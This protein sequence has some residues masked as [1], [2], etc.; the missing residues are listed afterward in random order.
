MLGKKQYYEKER[1]EKI[2]YETC[3]G[4]HLLF[5]RS[6]NSPGLYVRQ[7]HQPRHVPL[8]PFSY[9]EAKW[10]EMSRVEMGEKNIQSTM[11][12]D[13]F[14]H[15]LKKLISLNSNHVKKNK[16]RHIFNTVFPLC[17]ILARSGPACDIFGTCVKNIY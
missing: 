13:G 15:H 9:R 6:L 17:V 7:I 8:C 4:S 1:Y 14:W 2:H 12:K 16:H 3:D 10:A 11:F 5:P